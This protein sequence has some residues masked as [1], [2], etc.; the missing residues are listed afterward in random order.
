MTAND[1]IT[2]AHGEGARASRSLIRDLI[3]S[4]FDNPILG[5]LQDASLLTLPQ[6][7][8]ALT[9]D[10]YVV[11][12]VQFP[13]GSIGSL[14][15]HGTVNDLSVSGASPRFLSVALIIEEGF[16]TSLLQEILDDMADAARTCGVQVVCG[17]TKV[18]PK[19]AADGL[20]INTSGVGEI[21]WEGLSAGR[22]SEGDAIIISGPIG[23]HGL[24]ILAA[25]EELQFDPPPRTDCGSLTPAVRS[26]Q[27]SVGEQVRCLRDATRGGV[28][29]VLHEWADECGHSIRLAESQ[30]PVTPEVRGACELLGVD[31]LYLANEG[32]MVI[33]V[34]PG[35]AEAAVSALR[36]CEQTRDA[37]VAGHVVPK[38]IAPVMMSTVLGSDRPI[39]EPHG[40]LLPRIC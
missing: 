29:A 38:R 28:A 6:S 40:R 9:T 30:V 35:A 23:R 34:E 2:L 10:S 8:F 4:R 22:I 20:F 39:D 13:G 27:D 17:D 5:R 33:A 1:K 3:L 26:L 18:V 36:S 11:S 25:R 21:V 19:G 14:A 15:V 16:R 31:P 7:Q 24:A 32:T 12:P 37:T